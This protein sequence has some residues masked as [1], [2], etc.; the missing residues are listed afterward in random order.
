[1]YVPIP[2]IS[3]PLLE[4]T[5]L[6]VHNPLEAAP[7]TVPKKLRIVCLRFDANAFLNSVRPAAQ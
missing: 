2:E 3:L 1:M 6:C 5:I 4:R 7:A